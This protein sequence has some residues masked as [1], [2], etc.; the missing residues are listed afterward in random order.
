MDTLLMSVSLGVT[1]CATRSRWR[2]GLTFAAAEAIM[3]LFGLFVGSALGRLVGNWAALMGGI[4]LVGVAIWLIF[5]E[6]DDDDGK[7]TRQL[8]LWGLLFTAI[9]VSVDELAV[10]LSMGFMQLPVGLLVILI[11]IQAFFFTWLGL[12]FGGRLKKHLGEWSEKVAGGM[13]GL[14]GLWVLIA[15]LR[16]IA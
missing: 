16:H 13:L 6:N 7:R 5:F 12:T 9:S 10:G 11:A 3:P 1:A 2:I 8:T 14:L 15:A 4:A